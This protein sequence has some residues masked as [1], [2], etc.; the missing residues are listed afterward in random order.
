M[1][2]ISGGSVN[3]GVIVCKHCGEM[4]DTVDTEKVVTFYS[5]CD[6]E[7][8]KQLSHRSQWTSDSD[9]RD[10]AVIKP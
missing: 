10:L 3:L 4:I 5:Q 6:H 7:R 9:D 8:C 2:S 1:R